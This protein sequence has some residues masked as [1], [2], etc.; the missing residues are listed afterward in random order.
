MRASL[1]AM[2]ERETPPDDGTWLTR[3]SAGDWMRAALGELERAYHALADK[4]HREGLTHARRAA[5]MAL[6]ARLRLAPSP[7]Y[8]RTFVEHLH[9]FVAD[10]TSPAD[11]VLAARALLDAPA[12]PAL[13]TLGRGSVALADAARAILVTVADALPPEIT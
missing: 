3:L 4:R 8:G 9:A 6:N 11:A 12:K 5:G 2:A 1:A 7:A 13:V 10:P